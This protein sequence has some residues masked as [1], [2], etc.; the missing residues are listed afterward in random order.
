MPRIVEDPTQAVCPS[1]ERE[2]WNFL[3]QSVINGHQGINPLT[4]E[5]ATQQMKEAWAR[6]NSSKVAAWNA[7]LEHDQAEQ[8]EQDRL[9]QEEEAAQRAQREKEAEEQRKEADKKKPKMNVFNPDRGIPDW[10]E[11]R[12]A[13]YALNKISSLE[14][15]EL[16][17]FTARGCKA[18]G[19]D[20]SKSISHDTLAFTQFEDTIAIRP[21][22]A[23]RPSRNI[24]NDEDLSWDEM[25]D[26]KNTMLHFIAKSG[27]WPSANAQ[28][29]AAFYVI[30][31][32]HPRRLQVNGRQALLLYQSRARREWFDALKRDEGFNI[33]I[34]NENLLRTLADGLNDRIRDKKIDQV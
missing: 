16:D 25:M 24:R 14:Y 8:E 15:I 26:A 10:V 1:F 32:L 5:E 28:S 33:E 19:A 27:V 13:Q 9:A 7:Q 2:E 6:E 12:P 21:L 17:Y 23:V 11:P 30:L 22:A 20:T 3:R 18:A 34:I 29:L 4:E 31:D